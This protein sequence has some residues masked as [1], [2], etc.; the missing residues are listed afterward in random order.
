MFLTPILATHLRSNRHGDVSF[1]V[2][3]VSIPKKEFL[4]GDCGDLEEKVN[5]L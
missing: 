3:F 4:G 1:L 5:L 2:I